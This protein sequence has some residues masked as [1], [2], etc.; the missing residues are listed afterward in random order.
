MESLT[1]TF[2]ISIAKLIFGFPAPIIL[3]IL[4]NELSFSTVQTNCAIPYL[5][6][7]FRFVGAG[8]RVHVYTA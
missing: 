2:K 4:L 6:A 3:A 1:N 7:P 8:R 5:F